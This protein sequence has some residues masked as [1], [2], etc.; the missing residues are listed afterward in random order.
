MLGAKPSHC[1][2]QF[3]QEKSGTRSFYGTKAL[4]CSVW[5][6]K[7]GLLYGWLKWI[8]MLGV[9]LGVYSPSECSRKQQH[10]PWRAALSWLVIPQCAVL[11]IIQMKETAL[12][13]ARVCLR[14]DTCQCVDS[15][16]SW[17]PPPYELCKEWTQGWIYRLLVCV[18]G[19]WAL[20]KAPFP[21]PSGKTLVGN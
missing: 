7:H 17:N 1:G 21:F 3:S 19:Y 5:C 20:V 8:M 2:F 13:Q 11:H 6:L 18:S 9:D 4:F 14:T 15:M 16:R 12:K 10:Q